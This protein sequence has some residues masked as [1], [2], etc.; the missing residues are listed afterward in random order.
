M[1]QCPA[2]GKI[3]TGCRKVGHFKKVCHNSKDCAVHEVEADVSQEEGKIEEMSINSVYLNNKQSLITAQLE[4]QV[5]ENTIKIPYKIDTSSEANLMP[6]Y[7]FKKLCGNR[8]VEQLKRSIKIN[9]KLKMYNGTQIEQL[10][11]CTATIKFKNFKKKRVFFVVP[12][13]GQAL[14]GIPNTGTLN[15][16]NL[17]TDSIQEIRECKTNR[18]QETHADTEDC[19]NKDAHSPAKQDG[20]GQQHQANK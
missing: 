5:S 18:G 19:T 11:M 10:G 12:G 4:T 16:I 6:L 17:N 8:L 3:C 15:I 20:M 1:R 9:I 2:Y 7:I 13:N 14:L